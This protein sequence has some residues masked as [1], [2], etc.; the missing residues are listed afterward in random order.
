MVVGILSAG[1]LIGIGIGIMIKYVI[2]GIFGKEGRA[3]KEMEQENTKLRARV[4]ELEKG[5]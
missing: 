1:I 4:K 2:D 3:W 5:R